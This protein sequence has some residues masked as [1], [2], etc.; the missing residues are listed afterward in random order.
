MKGLSRLLRAGEDAMPG[1]GAASHDGR[2]CAGVGGQVAQW[3]WDSTV[4]AAGMVGSTP[5]PFL[6]RP[7]NKMSVGGGKE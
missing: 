7:N 5:N 2:E 1:A 4:R 6:P 3:R